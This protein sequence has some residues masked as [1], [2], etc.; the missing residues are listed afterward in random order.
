MRRRTAMLQIR[1]TNTAKA[2][3]TAAASSVHLPLSEWV[4]AACRSY[5]RD[6][7]DEAIRAELVRL[8]SEISRLGGNLNQ[9]MA[10]AN[11]GLVEADQIVGSLASIAA[12]RE[13]VSDAVKRIVA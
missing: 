11:S 8:R 2:T 6:G 13:I 12:M 9:T 3:W 10:A 7:D 5:S 4:R 1:V